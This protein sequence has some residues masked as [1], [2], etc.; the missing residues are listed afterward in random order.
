MPRQSY[1]L[2]FW[3]LILAVLDLRLNGFDVLP[4]LVG[5][6][7]I[8]LAATR[9]SSISPAF[10]RVIGPTAALT[11][12]DV[13]GFFATGDV[14]AILGHVQA[15]LGCVMVWLLLGAVATDCGADGHHDLVASAHNRRRWYVGI[16]VAAYAF[17]FLASGSPELSTVL[18]VVGAIAGVIVLVLV[19]LVLRSARLRLFGH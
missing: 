14:V 12:L 9:I 4:D 7:L 19:L 5:Y 17:L 2:F 18:V 8:W 3:G 10:R 11:V 15:V 16:T 1:S 13:V 6:I